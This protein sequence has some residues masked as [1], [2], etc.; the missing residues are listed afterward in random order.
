MIA[1]VRTTEKEEKV[2]ETRGRDAKSGGGRLDLDKSSYPKGEE[3]K[4]FRKEK[5]GGKTI[6]NAGY[7]NN[8]IK[9][10]R[11]QQARTPGPRG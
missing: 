2:G 5:R 8:N 4:G 3:R 10:T 1:P 7:R 11:L 9:P 6:M